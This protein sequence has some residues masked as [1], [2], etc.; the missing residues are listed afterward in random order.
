M[1]FAIV[2]VYNGCKKSAF[3]KSDV[4]LSAFTLYE[5]ECYVKRF[6]IFNFDYILD[7]QYCVKIKDIDKLPIEP[8]KETDNLEKQKQS[9]N[10][11]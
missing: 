1:E 2:Y 8:Y 6:C 4:D 7:I 9:N 5:V 11:K 10:G 3:V